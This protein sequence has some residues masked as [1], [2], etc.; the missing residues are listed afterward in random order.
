MIFL[1]HEP[2]NTI[3]LVFNPEHMC[4]GYTFF[5]MF[6]YVKG[7]SANDITHLLIFLTPSLPFV[8]HFT[9]QAYGV[10]SPFGRSSLPP[11]WVTSFMD[12]P[13]IC[14]VYVLN[15]LTAQPIEGIQGYP[16]L[17]IMA[18]FGPFLHPLGYYKTPLLNDFPFP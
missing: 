9:K 4:R 8:T 15:R 16:L 11:K 3:L 2:T 13:P 5:K 12:G 1:E 17:P 7:P 6:K 18:H 14:H 10:S